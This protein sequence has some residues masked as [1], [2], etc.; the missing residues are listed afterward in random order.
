MSD[1]DTKNTIVVFWEELRTQFREAVTNVL[2]MIPQDK[3]EEIKEM[4]E[5]DL[6]VNTISKIRSEIE[7][8]I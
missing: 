7:K 6:G 5:G 2:W 4:L 3:A 1:L 8:I